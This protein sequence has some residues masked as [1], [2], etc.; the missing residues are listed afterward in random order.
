MNP[1]ASHTLS[2]VLSQT[3]LTSLMRYVDILQ[4]WNPRIR[5]TGFRSEGEICRH[6]LLE[7][8]LAYNYLENR[9]PDS[10]PRVDFGSGNGS[11]GLILALID[12]N[13][14]YILVERSGKKRTFL[15][16]AARHLSLTNVTIL[17][18]IDRP[19]FFP[20]VYMKAIT[21]RDFLFDPMVRRFLTSSC[22]FIRFGDDTSPSCY[23]LCSCVI[24]GGIS[25]WTQTSSFSLSLFV[26][27]DDL[28]NVPRG[29]FPKE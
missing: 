28:K 16:Y 12:P 6:L 23:S 17:P 20:I 9:L 22:F 29:T 19:L 1:I 4:E 24:N 13:H 25:Q 11:P 15:D 10:F 7:P 27:R 21:I 3:T 18:A 26:F 8:I 5:L 2:P 14:H